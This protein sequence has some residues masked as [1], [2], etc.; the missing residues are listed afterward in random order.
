MAPQIYSRLTWHSARADAT[1]R[2]WTVGVQA[3]SALRASSEF[4]IKCRRDPCYMR[5]FLLWLIVV[6]TVMCRS[7]LSVERRR[8][9]VVITADCR[10]GLMKLPGFGVSGL[11]IQKEYAKKRRRAIHLNLRDHQDTVVE[12]LV[13]IAQKEGYDLETRKRGAAE[14]WESV[15]QEITG[16]LQSAALTINL[17]SRGWFGSQNTYDEYATTYKLNIKSGA[18]AGNPGGKRQAIGDQY[19]A[20]MA[21]TADNIKE[22]ANARLIA[23]QQATLSE[24]WKTAGRFTQRKR[25][26]KAMSATDGKDFDGLTATD[27]SKL[28]DV[29]GRDADG[30]GILIDNKKFKVSSKQIFAALNYGR[31]LNGSNITYGGSYLKL[32]DKLKRRAIYFPSDTFSIGRTPLF[33]KQCTYETLGVVMGYCGVDMLT[34]IWAGCFS[35]FTCENTADPYKLL[36]AHIFDKVK[37]NRDVEALYLSPLQADGSIAA[38]A[39]WN[40]IKLHASDWCTRNSVRLHLLGG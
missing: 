18:D 38:G 26:Y 23:D 20:G 37:M 6:N 31:R 15:Y 8:A 9:G 30:T 36:E 25:I 4:E 40:T 29:G 17:N 7:V 33:T 2:C 19:K 22:D 39:E 28:N 13:R 5:A 21:K 35:G 24:D 11:S 16:K 27:I 34:D 32:N 12:A 14:G 10:G 1:D 3:A